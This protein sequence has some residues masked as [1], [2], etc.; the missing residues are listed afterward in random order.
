MFTLIRIELYKI[1]RKWRSYIGFI[2]ITL[3]VVIIQVAISYEGARTLNFATRSL[4]QSFVFV[5]NFLN[6]Y[7]VSHIIMNSLYIHI[8]FLVALV[9]GDLMAGEA[10]AGTYRMLITRPVS[11]FDIVTAKFIAG[12]IYTAL[13]IIW[14]AVLS[15]GLGTI[16]FGTGELLTLQSSVLVIFARGDIL[17][18]FVYAYAFAVVSMSVVAALAFF[19]SSLVENSIGPIITTMAIIIAF[20]IIS[21]IDV[22]V[23]QS[24]KPYLFTNY[25]ADWKSFFNKPTDYS[26][27]WNSLL[28]LGIHIFGLYGLTL[29]LFYRKDILT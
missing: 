15:M 9:A 5:G 27:V 3:L 18:R 13:L 11:R 26:T 23:F 22:S 16:L 7:L 28:I 24:I 17:W 12:I 19:L 21:A 4:Q 2:A 10:T 25:M 6:G 1:F 14:L 29:F 20:I 8:P